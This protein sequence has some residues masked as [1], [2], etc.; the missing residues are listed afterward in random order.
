MIETEGCLKAT[1]TSEVA[2]SYLKK[3][4]YNNATMN[5]V[6]KIVSLQELEG[7]LPELKKQGKKIVTTNGAFDL[8]HI[9]HKRALEKSKSL[10]DVLIVM[11]NSDSSVKQ[12]KSDLR[13][14]IPEEE[15]A[16][17]LA[18]LSCVD[19]VTIFSELDPRNLL[20]KIKPDVHTKGGDYKPEGLLE[21]DGISKNGGTIVMT[22]SIK[23]TTG[24]IEKI[25]K[26]Y[27]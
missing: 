3:Q 19:Y 12:Y 20:E 9:G 21:F 8:L 23:S 18:G 27:G 16:E 15:R 25:L 10:G 22:E 7:I 14:I 6:Q 4:A 24:I 2:F 11:V 13:P 26:I 17:M 1:P 5:T